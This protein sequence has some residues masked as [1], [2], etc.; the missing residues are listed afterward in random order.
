MPSPGVCALAPRKMQGEGVGGERAIVLGWGHKTLT[1][2]GR[3]TGGSGTAPGW[4]VWFTS[5]APASLTSVPSA[6]RR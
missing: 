5:H 6:P 2:S 4:G 1:V 3:L